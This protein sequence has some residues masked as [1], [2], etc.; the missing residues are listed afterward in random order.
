MFAKYWFITSWM[1]VFLLCAC[2]PKARYVALEAELEDSK[3]Q[4]ERAETKLRQLEGKFQGFEGRF[5]GIERDL[6]DCVAASEQCT[7]NL[8]NLKTRHVYV[9]NINVQLSENI[10]RMNKELNRSRSVVQLQEK[11]IRLLDDTKKT[12]ETSLKD[13]I[14]AQEIE[15]IEQENQLKVVFVDKILFDSGSVNINKRGKELLLIMAEPLK[16]NKDQNIVIDGHTD[17]VP[18]RAASMERFPSN[19]ELSC[20]RAAAVARYFQ[21]K[22]GIDPRRLSIRGYSYYRP[23]AQN[24]TEEGRRQNRRI[25]IILGPAW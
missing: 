11:V 1:I 22:G 20:A 19:W 6:N 16:A 5:Q 23:V 3:I 12:I 7:A 4:R 13:Q 25:E 8:N 9:K 21:E 18:L 24:T 2:V 14:A 17:D 15:V 10:K